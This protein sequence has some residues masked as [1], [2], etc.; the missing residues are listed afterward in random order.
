[1]AKQ[2]IKKHELDLLAQECGLSIHHECGGSRVIRLVDGR[3]FDIYPSGGVCPVRTMQE[4]YTFLEGWAAGAVDMKDRI[5][6]AV[7]LA[8]EDA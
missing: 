7:T 4:C 1:M 5:D 2:R 6:S 3:P 8:I